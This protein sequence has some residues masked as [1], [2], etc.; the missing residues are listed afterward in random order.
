MGVD[1]CTYRIQI[2]TFVRPG[3]SARNDCPVWLQDEGL[4]RRLSTGGRFS[5]VLFCIDQLLACAGDKKTNPGPGKLDQ[6]PTLF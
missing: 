3:C 2:D 6:A 1:L 5:L 4:N